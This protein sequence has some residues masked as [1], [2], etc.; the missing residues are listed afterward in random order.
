MDRLI[1]KAANVLTYIGILQTFAKRIASC[2]H[3]SFVCKMSN[4]LDVSPW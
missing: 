4:N 3:T 2:L 1:T